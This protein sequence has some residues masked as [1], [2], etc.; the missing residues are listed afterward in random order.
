MKK[1]VRV[2]VVDDCE[3]LYAGI[4]RALTCAN[5]EIIGEACD[6]ATALALIERERPDIVLLDG[7]LPDLCGR[8]I[9]EIAKARGTAARFVAYSAHE[10]YDDVMGMVRAGAVGFVIQDEA[11]KNLI[12]AIETAARGGTWFSQRIAK[13]LAEWAQ[14]TPPQAH[15]LSPQELRVLCLMA[16][17]KSDGAIIQELNI[18]PRTLRHHVRNAMDKVGVDTRAKLMLWALEN[19]LGEKQSRQAQA[20]H[21][22]SQK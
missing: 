17:A 6:G 20:P 2:L 14:T 4:R 19:G 10:E 15:S 7:R 22:S 8:E 18:S 1:W 11:P 21:G 12:E 5:C 16:R 13:K 9:V 3:M